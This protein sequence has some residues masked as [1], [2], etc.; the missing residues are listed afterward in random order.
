MLLKPVFDEETMLFPILENMF[1]KKNIYW[2]I[3]A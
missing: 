2:N 1:L 3:K